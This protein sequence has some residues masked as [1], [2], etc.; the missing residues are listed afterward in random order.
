MKT[1]Y[2]QKSSC[3]FYSLSLVP[4][5]WCF[6]FFPCMVILIKLPNYAIIH[7]KQKYF[8]VSNE[9]I[10]SLYLSLINKSCSKHTIR[11]IWTAGKIKWQYFCRYKGIC[12]CIHSNLDEMNKDLRVWKIFCLDTL[13][14]LFSALILLLKGCR[15]SEE[16][17]ERFYSN[18]DC[19]GGDLTY[20]ISQAFCDLSCLNTYSFNT[21]Y[22]L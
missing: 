12:H 18:N 10:P 2:L 13:N 5:P 4:E 14:F 15:I 9:T 17:L 1:K 7:G 16:R 20:S 3:L 11:L 22:C 19:L 6:N 21:L 8:H